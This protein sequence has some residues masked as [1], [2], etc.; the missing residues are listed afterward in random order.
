M[1]YVLKHDAL[2]RYDI[3]AALA[4]EIGRF[5]VTW[6]Y[7]EQYVQSIIWHAMQLQHAEGRI[8]VREP[9]R[10]T[11]RIDMLRDLAEFQ[12]IEM[13]YVLLKEIRA[14]VE[15]LASKRNL[16]AH[17]MWQRPQGYWV[18]VVTRGSWQETQDEIDNYPTGSK[19]VEPEA[20]EIT[21]DDV[22]RW[23]EATIA[24]IGDV[25]K[26]NDNP[27]RVPLREKQKK[28]SVPRGHSRGRTGSGHKSPRPASRE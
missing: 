1:K 3:P 6:A 21:A 15:A 12:K 4:R 8:A 5:L 10:L 28:R 17:S 27:R 7:F 14:G 16:L 20:I 25:E 23:R 22:R 24:L 18:A 11:D 26:L 2:A 19:G 9:P 13:D